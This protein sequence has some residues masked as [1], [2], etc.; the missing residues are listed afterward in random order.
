VRI[1]AAGEDDL[2]VA[3]LEGD[4]HVDRLGGKALV[5]DLESDL[6]P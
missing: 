2:V 4:R 6:L 1:G 3:I 5:E